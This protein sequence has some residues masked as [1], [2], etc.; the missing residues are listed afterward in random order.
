MAKELRPYQKHAIQEIWQALIKDDEPVLLMASVGSGKS[1]MIADVLLRMERQGKRALCIVN[2]AQLVKG[3]CETYIEQGGNASIYC[4][5][6]KRKDCSASVVFATPQ[7]LL[8]GIRKDVKISTIEFNLIVVDE[9][10]NINYLDDHSYFMRILRHYK[11][12]YNNMR[13][14]GATGTNYRFK[15]FSIVGDEC[16]FKSQVGNITTEDLI[17]KGYLVSPHF[18]VDEN[19]VI[20]FTKVRLKRNGQFDSRQLEQVIER[21]HRLTKLICEQIVHIIEEQN[22]FGVF[23]FATTKKHAL[24]II[25]HLPSDQTR[26][27]LGETPEHERTQILDQAR[28]G[29]VRYLVN[30]A[31]ISVGIDIPSYDTIAYLRPTESLV[32]LVQTLGRSLRLS[33]QTGKE[34]ALIMDF[35]GNI[36]RHSHWDN[37]ILLAA[38]EETIDEDKPYDIRCPQCMIMNTQTAR[39]C[40]GV[41]NKKRCDYYFKFKE[42]ICGVVNDITARHCRKCERE[43]IDPN[44]KLSLTHIKVDVREYV[45]IETRYGINDTKNGFRINCIYHCNENVFY[46]SYSPI[47]PKAKNVFYGKFIKHHC[48]KPSDWYMKI[49]DKEKMEEMLA[50]AK[51][52]E[53]IFVQYEAGGYKITNKVF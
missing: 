45:V 7:T 16:F 24:E 40:I 25:G 21:S 51:C 14:L 2:N 31:I 47:S 27:I 8:N 1:L 26:L 50:E 35:A 30:I 10:H 44:K 5:A 49:G 39:R 23:I 28:Q 37:P 29:T 12:L 19:L 41:T 43:L 38:L 34:S 18:K 46:E 15:G 13:V 48:D 53:T 6:L 36:E 32:L 3:N 4:A 9:A 17:E 22:R 42:C 33:P 11:Q 52:P 20:D